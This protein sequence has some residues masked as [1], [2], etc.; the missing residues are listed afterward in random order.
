MKIYIGG[1]AMCG[2]IGVILFMGDVSLKFAIGI[3]VAI[4][5]WSV[6]LELL[7]D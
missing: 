6:S 5:L 4:F 2:A 1:V 3:P 7:K